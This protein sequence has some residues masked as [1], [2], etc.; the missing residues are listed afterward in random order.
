[1]AGAPVILQVSQNTVRYHGGLEPVALATLSIAPRAAVPVAVHLD[2]AE[3]PEL[4]HEAVR[5]GFTSVMFDASNLAYE[6]NVA[7]T[8]G[9]VGHCHPRG[10]WGGG[11]AR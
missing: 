11:G 9:G 8:A 5:L 1:R 3:S 6:A 4:V 7:A 2:H 10:G